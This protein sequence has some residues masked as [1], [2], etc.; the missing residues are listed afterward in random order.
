MSTVQIQNRERWLSGVPRVPGPRLPWYRRMLRSPLFWLTVVLLPFY[1]YGLWDQYRMLHPD[2]TFPDGTVAL[3]LN[4]DSL[5]FAAFWAMWTAIA[6]FLLFLWLDRFRPQRPLVWLLTFAW[7]A[8][9]S[10]W[11]SIH[12]NSWAGQ[13]MATTDANADMGT[14]AAIFIAPFVE[15]STK[16]TVLFLLVILNRRQIVSRL[17]IVTLAGLSAIGFAFVENIIYYARTVVYA[18]NTI[19][20]ED[21]YAEVMELVMLR[22]VY[23][24]FGHPLFGM[25]TAFGL[26]IGLAARSKIVR[27]AAPLG[28]FVA[29]SGGHMLFNGVASTNAPDQLK[30]QWYMALGLVAVLTLFLVLTVVAQAQLIRRR[31]GDYRRVGWLTDRDLVVF[32]SPF[33]RM[34]LHLAGIFRGPRKWWAT[35]KF[36]R[37]MTELA[38]LREG[39]TRGLVA[40]AGDWRAHELIHEIEELRPTA[41]TDTAGLKVFP[42]RKRKPKSTLP[43]PQ[44][45]GP[46]GIG[47]N[48]PAPR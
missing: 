8:C 9:A 25:M 43:P 16:A 42:P 21:P 37:R 44:A 48:W 11:M 19:G 38:Y 2:T 24:S 5:R 46:A 18:T 14:R 35:A 17:S 7:G 34:K 45:P 30:T 32:S 31:L 12:A 13:M 23:T 29:A 15:E 41:L 22:G 36:M 4:H 20:I 40:T 27:V 28:G 1:A 39:R 47:G 3:G 10:T 33:K 26:A 6:Y